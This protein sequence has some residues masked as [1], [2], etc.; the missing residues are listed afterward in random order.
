MLRVLL[1]VCIGCSSC[2]EAPETLREEI[3]EPAAAAWTELTFPARDG[4][5]GAS[6]TATERGIL[7]TWIESVGEGHRVRFARWHGTWDEAMTVAEGEDLIANWADF[8]RSALGGDDAVYV[9]HLHR[10]GDAPY[11]YEIRLSRMRG[12]T[13]ESLGVVHRD[14]T[15]TE[16]GFVSMVP[17][18]QGVRLFWLDGRAT[19]EDGATQVFT[20]EV[21]DDIG[22][23]RSLDERVC[24]CCQ[25]DAVE[26]HRGPLVAFRDRSADETRDIAYAQWTGDAF[27]APQLVHADGWEIAGC[28]VNGPQVAAEGDSRVVAWF[29]GAR[30]GAVYAAFDEGDAFG[31]PIEVDGRQPPG[32]VDVAALEGGAAVSWLARGRETGEVRVRFVGRDGRVGAPTRVGT[33]SLARAS[34]FPVMV[35]WREHLYVA[36]RRDESVRFARLAIGA[37][38]RSPG[39]PEVEPEASVVVGDSMPRALVE[40]AAGET[41]DLA[42]HGPLVVAFY[43]RWCQP[44]REEL[45]MLQSVESPVIAVSIDEG[46]VARAQHVARSWGFEGEVVRDAGAAAALGVPPLPGTFVVDA[47]GQIRLR[48][49]GEVAS[50]DAIVDALSDSPAESDPGNRPSR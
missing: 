24:D 39:E 48:A 14:G 31:E 36:H 28:P 17:T 40:D 18:A 21:G 15:P 47:R 27:S 12:E 13:F 16:H 25:T 46:S 37:L 41:R 9:H 38:P 43:A 1:L 8:P 22:E 23:A 33:A 20:T 29:T 35:R 32:R 49:V 44:C 4:A 45:R 30:G 10:S 5:M 50:R 42:A 7:A 19:V 34:G 3:P 11:A 6:L 2:D 26:T